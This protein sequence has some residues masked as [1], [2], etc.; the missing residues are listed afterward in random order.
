MTHLGAGY[1]DRVITSA[2]G[3]ELSGYGFYLERRAESVLDDLRVRA[4]I[5]DDGAV[6]LALISFDLIGFAV[7]FADR[8][9]RAVSEAVSIEPRNILLACT[10]THT[11]PATQ[12]LRG[13]GEVD[14]AY[15]ASLPGA[16]VEAAAAALSDVAESEL[17]FGFEAVEAIGF[18]RRLATFEGID[19]LLKTARFKRKDGEIFLLNY[20]CHPV[21]LGRDARV[22]GDWPGAAV[23][24]LEARGRRAL[25]FQGFCGD[26]DPVTNLNRWGRGTEED[27][28]LY[29]EILAGRALKSAALGGRIEGTNAPAR[30]RPA[31]RALAAAEAR[32]R[33]PL[34]VPPAGEIE[35]LA[36]L[37]RARNQRFPAA[38][39]F[40]SEWAESAP[41]RRG[42]LAEMP[43]LD[44]VPVQAMAIGGLKIIAFPGEVFTA[45]SVALKKEFPTLFPIGYANGNIGYLPSRA[46]FE[47]PDDYAAVFA[48]MF[49]GAFP[50]TLD[51][52]ALLI[53]TA[54]RLLLNLGT[55]Y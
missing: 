36:A 22:S 28:G 49:Y 12:A 29:G 11:G 7:D 33:V 55:Q 18:N 6:R 46:A 14:A 21:T 31:G 32:V 48:P 30:G 27:L 16:A 38:D 42:E 10:H 52:P 25:V 51:L 26:I 35:T 9:R 20:A 2:L 24:A 13:I 15:L 1:A 23:R 39:R 5:L 4:L 41:T 45:Y 50:F 54:R 3:L 47:D 17:W 53:S 40:A 37:F 8:L 43:Y 44:N 19:P 34:E